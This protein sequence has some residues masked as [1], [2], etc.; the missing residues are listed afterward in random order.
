GGGVIEP[1][2]IRH[3]LGLEPELRQPVA[4][5]FRDLLALGC[6]GHVRLFGEG[7]QPGTGA[8]GGRRGQHLA[9]RLALGLAAAGE[10]AESRRGRPLPRRVACTRRGPAGDGDEYSDQERAARGEATV[11]RRSRHADPPIE[12][13]WIAE[14]R[15]CSTKTRVP[16]RLAEKPP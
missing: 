16:L 3:H 14:R 7:A 5:V 12:W 2:V 4:H 11:P 6:P 1:D 10:K 13:V 15:Q 9:L 8:L